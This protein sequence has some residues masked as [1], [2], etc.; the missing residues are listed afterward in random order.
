[1]TEYGDITDVNRLLARPAA[2]EFS[3][4][5]DETTGLLEEEARRGRLDMAE[6]VGG[7]LFYKEPPTPLVVVG[8][9]HGDLDTLR[10]ILLK[11]WGLVVSGDATIVFLGDYIDRGPPEGQVATLS[12]LMRLKLRAPERVVLL[13]GNHEPPPGLEPSP[14]D[15]PVA[16]MNLYD[17][18]A[19][20][21]YRLSRRLFDRMPYAVHVRDWALLMHGGIPTSTLDRD[22]VEEILGAGGDPPI[23]VL[24][25]ILWN[26]PSEYVDFRRPSMRGIGYEWGPKATMLALEKLGVK[27]II[28]GHE[29]VYSGFKLN[30]NGRVITLFSRR[31]Y[32]Y[33]NPEAAFMLCTSK[34]SLS[35]PVSCIQVIS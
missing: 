14:H 6:R 1:M 24:A 32:P 17:R 29:A 4:L 28:R 25:E 8:D 30:H 16:L 10:A 2:K 22:R 33:N 19:P 7:V 21:L 13:R 23:N 31:G 3:E 15:Y 27:N 18:D 35:S 26:D 9:I 20:E 34:D 12:A 11:V 5:L